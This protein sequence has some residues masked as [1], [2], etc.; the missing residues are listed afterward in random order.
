MVGCVNAW[1]S[2]KA[3]GENRRAREEEVLREKRVRE[4]KEAAKRQSQKVTSRF[5]RRGSKGGAETASEAPP[6]VNEGRDYQQR[7]S[8]EAEF[9]RLLPNLELEFDSETQF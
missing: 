2:Q 8:Q 4:R 5:L 9:Q 1:F 6:Q 7:W 3:V